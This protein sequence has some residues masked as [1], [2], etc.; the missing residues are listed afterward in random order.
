[1]IGTFF[2]FIKNENNLIIR[3]KTLESLIEALKNEHCT[4]SRVKI[5][6]LAT[7]CLACEGREMNKEIFSYFIE[8][9]GE[10]KNEKK[11]VIF[12][13]EYKNIIEPSGDIF[14]IKNFIHVL[15]HAKLLLLKIAKELSNIEIQI[16][17]EKKL[18]YPEDWKEI[19]K[20]LKALPSFKEGIFI[21][22]KKKGVKIP[23]SYA[24]KR[25]HNHFL[26]PL[27]TGLSIIPAKIAALFTASGSSEFFA[28]IICLLGPI[29]L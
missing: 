27:R 28:S 14:E 3:T 2:G 23:Y 11:E 13:V 20:H 24:P 15:D 5:T 18:F 21:S 25:L 19:S 16:L 26:H 4:L 8:I 29:T 1:M 17:L 10:N 9:S 7:A 22:I 6:K 12:T